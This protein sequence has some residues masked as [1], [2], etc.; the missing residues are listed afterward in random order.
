MRLS[1]AIALVA[2]SVTMSGGVW[3]KD[4][5]LFQDQ[6]AGGAATAWTLQPPVNALGK[7]PSNGTWRIDRG[8]FLATG[9]AAPWT[10]ETAG[11]PA[12]SDYSLGVDVTIRKPGSRADFPICHAEWDRYLPRDWFP[13]LAEHT[14]Q[15]RYRY[16]AGEFDWGSEACVY[17]RSRDRENCYR[18]QLSTEYQ[19][20]ILWHG[21]GGYLQI[22]PCKVEPGKTYRLEVLA[23][24]VHLQVLLDGKKMIDYWHE[25]LPALTGGIGLGAYHSTVGFRNVQVRA[26]PPAGPV[27]VHKALFNTR[28]WRTVRWLFD[29]DEPICLFEKS[30]T[31]PPGYCA[32]MLSYYHVKLRPGYRPLYYA[33]VGLCL[34]IPGA[35]AVPSLA[36]PRISRPR[37]RTPSALGFSSPPSFRTNPWMLRTRIP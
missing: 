15:Y 32:G 25:C 24:G 11:D 1:M 18:V 31:Q 9:I 8:E 21:I 29:G 16:Y 20:M 36:Q 6:F 22:V 28:N 23:Q 3:A 37:A 33:W 5:V 27:P 10:V 19:E 35:R 14:G 13:P 2:L 17:V 26:L 12:W 4:T 7:I 34:S 30:P